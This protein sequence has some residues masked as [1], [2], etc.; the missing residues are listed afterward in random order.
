VAD[1]GHAAIVTSTDNYDY[2]D[3]WHY[4]A[5][6]YIDLGRRFADQIETVDTS[7]E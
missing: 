7:D 1:D 3:T 6:S 5:A 2:S 4:D